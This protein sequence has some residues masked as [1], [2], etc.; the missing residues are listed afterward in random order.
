MQ[1]QMQRRPIVRP[2][3]G[4][5]GRKRTL[6]WRGGREKKSA[7]TQNYKQRRGLRRMPT[8][9]LGATALRGG[10]L[11]ARTRR[12]GTRCARS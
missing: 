11:R 12:A 1:P 4:A 3:D 10:R 5:G 2:L 7:L 9:G 8:A 6:P